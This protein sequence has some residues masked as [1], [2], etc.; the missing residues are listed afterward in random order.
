M[1]RINSTANPR[2]DIVPSLAYK[3]F[4]VIVEAGR[5]AGIGGDRFG[6][7]DTDIVAGGFDSANAAEVWITRYRPL[8][9]VKQATEQALA[10]GR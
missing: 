8:L 2:F 1:Q 9:G 10:G 3:G 4:W 5:F 6:K 7:Y